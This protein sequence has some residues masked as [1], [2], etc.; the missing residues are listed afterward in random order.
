MNE[1]QPI[2]EE[3]TA[4]TADPAPEEAP[5]PPVRTIETVTKE[6][7]GAF[8]HYGHDS[9][10]CRDLL[11]ELTFLINGPAETPEVRESDNPDGETVVAGRNIV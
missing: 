11:T 9:V 4:A 1:G 8:T 5:A 7:C 10:K 3:S 6:L 2:E